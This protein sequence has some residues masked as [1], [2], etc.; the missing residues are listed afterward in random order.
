MAILLILLS[1]LAF[2]GTSTGSSGSTRTTTRSSS[3][4]KV[5][6]TQHVTATSCVVVT[7]KNGSPAHRHPCRRAAATRQIHIV[8]CTARLKVQVDA[9][10][11]Q[12][13]RRC[14]GPPVKP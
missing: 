1:L 8:K 7:W 10:V 6:V 5:T 4:S 12:K 13:L 9:R 11:V 2:W 14:G 3:S